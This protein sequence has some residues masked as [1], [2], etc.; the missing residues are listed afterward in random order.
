MGRFVS[1]FA[2][3]RTSAIPHLFPTIRISGNL[4]SG[5]PPHSAMAWWWANNNIRGRCAQPAKPTSRYSYIDATAQTRIW[6]KG[7]SRRGHLTKLPFWSL[8]QGDRGVQMKPPLR[9]AGRHFWGKA[10]HHFDA[11]HDAISARLSR[12][13]AM[14]QLRC[15]YFAQ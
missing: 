8:R 6:E 2:S 3:T 12:V 1:P 10:D 7:T 13:S 15:E 14:A 4:A 9:K 11:R 5:C